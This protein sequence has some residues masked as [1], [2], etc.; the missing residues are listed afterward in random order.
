[1]G[2]ATREARVLEANLDTEKKE[3]KHILACGS[4]AGGARPKALVRMDDCLWIA[5]FSS[6]RDSAPSLFVTLEQAG[7]ILA[8]Q[9]GLRVPD[10]NRVLV[11]D[12]DVLLIKRFDLA[13][14]GGRNAIVSM[15]TLTGAEDPYLLS[16]ADVAQVL[17]R[18]SDFPER[19]LELFFRWM[20]VNVLLQNTDDHLQNFS[21]LHTAS[22]WMLSPA[23]DITPN[24]YQD[25][26]ILRI[27]GKNSMLTRADLL[28]EG[29]RFG[30]SVQKSR[31]VLEEVLSRMA[32][33]EEVFEQCGVPALH[34]QKLRENIRDKQT[35]AGLS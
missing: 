27:N 29:R 19:D 8:R 20:L 21:M 5:K 4:S 30:L 9:A 34:T 35:L 10:L 31:R 1:M 23:Y 26:H 24:I 17:R 15:R 3:L 16:Y 7:M 6:I 25:S 32:N 13:A 33:W 28:S 2:A 12:R 14:A 22:G 11:E 18:V